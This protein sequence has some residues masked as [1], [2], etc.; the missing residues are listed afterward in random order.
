[1]S[2]T[3]ASSNALYAKCKAI[4]AKRITDK[5]FSDLAG[6]SDLAEFASHLKSRTSYAEAFDGLENVGVGKERL[7]AVIYRM[8]LL[9]F[10]HLSKYMDMSGENVKDY[11]L[12]RIEIDILL[13]CATRL[14]TQYISDPFLLYIPNEIKKLLCFSVDALLGAHDITEFSAALSGTRYEKTV[15][16]N[17][18]SNGQIRL[19]QLQN[20]LYKE[21]FENTVK[22][23][24]GK[25][26]SKNADVKNLLCSMSDIMMISGL[27]RAK[28]YYPQNAHMLLSVFRSSLS[29]LAEKQF[30]ALFRAE[31]EKKLLEEMKKFK[32][33][34]HICTI[35]EN[36]NL[37]KQALFCVCTKTLS[38][39]LSAP[40]AA[41]AFFELSRIE[42]TNLTLIVEG[43]SSAADTSLIMSL[44]IK[45]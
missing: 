35:F 41:I 38:R 16:T 45:E 33:L 8:T 31:N 9:R 22:T 34:R 18:M 25:D 37:E 23:L 14:G 40:C 19:S 42:S 36:K 39:T 7:E 43:I 17:R 32:K 1:M 29:H 11:F 44:L 21:L 3:N 6:L 20:A 2:N 26:Y 4:N 24:C 13:S 10:L 27:I 15:F 30:D 12:S 28:R 5:Q